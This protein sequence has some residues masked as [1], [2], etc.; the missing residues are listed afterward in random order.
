MNSMPLLMFPPRPSYALTRSF[1]SYSF[2][3]LT[4]LMAFLAPSGCLL[5]SVYY[6]GEQEDDY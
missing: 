4:T 5:V 3:L 2:A 6:R 1:F